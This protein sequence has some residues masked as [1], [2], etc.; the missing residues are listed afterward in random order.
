[1]PSIRIIL[2]ADATAGAIVPS[3]CSASKQVEVACSTPRAHCD[4]RTST[5]QA[6]RCSET[7]QVQ[8]F[9]HQQVNVRI[10]LLKQANLSEPRQH[11][12][13]RGQQG[14]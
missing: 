8:S 9:R 6:M 14:R 2:T 5:Q 3:T 11:G 12:G 1:M 4:L 10:R 7:L 13:R